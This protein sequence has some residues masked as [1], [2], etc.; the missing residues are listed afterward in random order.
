[1]KKKNIEIPSHVLTCIA[2]I[3][4]KNAAAKCSIKYSV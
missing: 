1:M 3:K 4:P 2:M